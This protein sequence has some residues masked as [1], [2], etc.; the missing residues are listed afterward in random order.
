MGCL[1]RRLPSL[2][3]LRAFEAAARR[4]SFTMAGEELHLTPSAISHQV[5]ALERHFGQKL[6]RREGIRVELT[7]DGARLAGR[8]QTA[9]D[10]MEKACSELERIPPDRRLSVLCAPSF[11]SKWLGPRLPHFMRACPSVA[12]R[13]TA[14][15]GA[16][17][18]TRHDELDI[19]ISYGAPLSRAGLVVEPLG[20]EEIVAL[21]AP[22][23]AER[24]DPLD[25]AVG[26]LLI[27]SS[28]NPVRWSDWFALNGLPEP[29]PASRPSFDRGALAVSAAAQGIGVALEGRRFAQSELASGEL[30]EPAPGR[31]RGVRRD[32]HFLSCREAA[33]GEPSITAFRTWLRAAL[34]EAPG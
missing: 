12:L 4:G 11:A 5:R 33:F 25:P 16:I 34:H 10:T 24:F 22:A 6:F 1:M 3:A 21:C 26:S 29:A 27:E 13:L 2:P 23:L 8:L 18:L 31:Y 17:D 32:M 14:E 15:A 7:A 20:V 30:V 19:V 28:V 9:F